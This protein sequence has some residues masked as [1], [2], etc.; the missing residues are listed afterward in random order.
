M[1]TFADFILGETDYFKKLQIAYYLQK[2][3]GIFFDNSVIFKTEL[4]RMFI[5]KMNLG[6]DKP[7]RFW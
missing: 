6:V 7:G 3:A 5:E 2:R 1:E 4:A